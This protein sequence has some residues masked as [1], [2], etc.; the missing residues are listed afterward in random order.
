MQTFVWFRLCQLLEWQQLF[1]LLTGSEVDDVLGLAP[2]AMPD[3]GQG[4]ESL[5]TR[6]GPAQSCTPLEGQTISLGR[7][8]TNQPR[9]RQAE[10]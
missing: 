9:A 3:W 4:V 5:R 2:P 6:G 8:H 1:H 7:F 10:S